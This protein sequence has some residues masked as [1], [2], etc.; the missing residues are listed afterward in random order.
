MS[1]TYRALTP[2]AGVL[3]QEGTFDA[4]F[5]PSEERDALDGGHLEIVPREYKVLSQNYAAGAQGEIVK[6][7][8][9]VDI[10]S[11]LISGGH[12]ERHEPKPKAKPAK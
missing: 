5:S 1:N 4:S 11:A 7:A 12:L 3:Y 9:L 8:L 6:L 2:Y 10:E